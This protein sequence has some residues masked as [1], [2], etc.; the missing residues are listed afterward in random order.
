MIFDV[1]DRKLAEAAQQES[2]QRLNGILESSQDIIWSAASDSLQMIYMSPSA[3]AVYGR[4]ISKFF[5]NPNLWSEVVYPEDKATVEAFF[6]DIF[7]AGQAECEYR[8]IMPDGSVRWLI[9]RTWLIQDEGGNAIRLDGIA[10]D[11]TTRKL[12]QQTIEEQAALLDI[13]NEAILVHKLTGELLYWNK[14]AERMYGWSTEEAL[15]QNIYQ[16]V[17]AD[18]HSEKQEDILQALTK[19]GSWQGELR[20]INKHQQSITVMSRRTLVKDEE[21]HVTSVLNVD[22]HY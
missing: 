7:E 15:S 12:A 6:A 5:D 17:Y 13:A 2:Q 10:H 21:G 16:L 11:I 1:C 4:P 3:E 22:R 8:I 20:K 19:S 14:G 9:D 18:G